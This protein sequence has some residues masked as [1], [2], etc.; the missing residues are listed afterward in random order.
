[1]YDVGSTISGFSAAMQ[2]GWAVAVQQSPLQVSLQVVLKLRAGLPS[3]L[4]G[5]LVEL[6]VPSLFC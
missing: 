2:F 4:P 3:G 1:M 6:K 5:F